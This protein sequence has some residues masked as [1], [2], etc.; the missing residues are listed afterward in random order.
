[1]NSYDVQYY[2]QV[3]GLKA[4]N[5]ALKVF[6]SVGGWAAGGAVFSTMV[7]S[8]ENRRTFIDSAIQFM[9]TYAFDGIDIDWE[10]PAA[11]DRGGTAA[12]TANFVEFLKE[13]R[14]ACG[15]QFGITATLPSSYW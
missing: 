11:S 6:I 14:A 1:M 13:L 15:K 2:P 8:A 10:Y 5:P 12:D 4:T 3:T 7:S 9:K